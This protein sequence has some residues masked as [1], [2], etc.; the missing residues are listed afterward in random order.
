MKFNERLRHY[1][2]IN[3]LS[4]TD[5]ANKLGLPFYLI[6]DYEKGRSEPKIAIL[7]KLARLYHVSVDTLVGFVPDGVEEAREKYEEL[8]KAFD[9]HSDEEKVELI[10]KALNAIK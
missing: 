1:R 9:S 4:Q 8:L 10:E 5:V 7:I 3:N 6:S 2:K